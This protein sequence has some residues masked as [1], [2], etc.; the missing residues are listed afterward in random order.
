MSPINFSNN[1]YNP[2][3]IPEQEFLANFVIR[4]H[5]FNEIFDDIKE[6]NFNTPSQHFII[7]GQRGQGKTCLLYTSPSPRD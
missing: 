7:V 3:N 2:D 4:H 1:K 6:S 5:E